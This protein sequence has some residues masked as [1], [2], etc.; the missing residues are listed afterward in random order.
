MM[1]YKIARSNNMKICNLFVVTSQT[2]FC[3]HLKVSYTITNFS[4][5]L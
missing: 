3:C 2:S 1:I 5:E 4:I